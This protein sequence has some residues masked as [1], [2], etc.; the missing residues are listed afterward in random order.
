MTA[1]RKNTS[2]NERA[3]ARQRKRRAHER[4]LHIPPV[5]HPRRRKAAIK[6]VLR[7]LRTYFADTFYEDFTSQRCAIVEAVLRAARHGGDQVGPADTAHPRLHDRVLDPQ[8]VAERRAQG[9][10]SHPFLR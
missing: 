5:A 8:Q 9:A 2:E 10:G 4:D 1:A 7:F 6:D 3:A